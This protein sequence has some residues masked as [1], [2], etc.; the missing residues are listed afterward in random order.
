MIIVFVSTITYIKKRCLC[1]PLSVLGDPP[2]GATSI[3]LGNRSLCIHYQLYQKE[4]SLY[5][6][7]SFR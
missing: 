6:T 5:Y 7:V 3:S 1:I 4:E 2:Q